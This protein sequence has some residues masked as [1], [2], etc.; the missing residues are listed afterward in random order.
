MTTPCAGPPRHPSAARPASLSIA[1]RRKATPCRL[2]RSGSMRSSATAS[3]SSATSRARLG[4]ERGIPARHCRRNSH[5]RAPSMIITSSTSARV[6]TRWH[7]PPHL[8]CSPIQFVANSD[9]RDRCVEVLRVDGDNCR[10]DRESIGAA[11]RASKPV[12]EIFCT[13]QPIRINH[14]FI[15]TSDHIPRSCRVNGE[16]TGSIASYGSAPPIPAIVAPPPSWTFV[17]APP[18]VK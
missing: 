18:A 10:Q 6:C 11:D 3:A 4:Q 17:Q 15:A 5:R 7:S 2:G 1:S 14:P 9:T 12:V 13:H 8:M 16:R